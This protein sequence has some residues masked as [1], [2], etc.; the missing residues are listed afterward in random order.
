MHSTEGSTPE[1]VMVA[2]TLTVPDCWGGAPEA[3]ATPVP[4]SATQVMVAMAASTGAPVRL[5]LRGVPCFTNCLPLP[6][7]GAKRRPAGVDPSSFS[8]GVLAGCEYRKQG[9]RQSQWPGPQMTKP[10]LPKWA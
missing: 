4:E 10:G 1:P 8:T 6:D 3:A 7:R 5:A 2:P 9:E